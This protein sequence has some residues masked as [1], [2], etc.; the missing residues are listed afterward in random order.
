MVL[1]W[2]YSLD[3][4][5]LS[6]CRSREAHL[7]SAFPFVWNEWEQRVLDRLLK[8]INTEILLV[9]RNGLADS[10]LYD[11]TVQV[12]HCISTYFSELRIS[13]NS[14]HLA[15]F[16]VLF[17]VW[18]VAQRRKSLRMQSDLK[19]GAH[20][21]HRPPNPTYGGTSRPCSKDS[22]INTLSL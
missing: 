1:T 21:P 20:L 19:K 5:S 18:L 13:W 16:S 12:C 15:G 10:S 22:L 2:R 11:D 8:I 7:I 17:A 9:Q 3:R 4:S 6:H 14:G